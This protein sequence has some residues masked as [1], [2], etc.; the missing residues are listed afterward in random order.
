M[1]TFETLINPHRPI[2]LKVVEITGITPQMV[3]GAP[4]IEE[5]LPHFLDFLDGAV[6]VAHNALFDLGFLNYELTRLKGRR[7]GDG[8]IDTV[9]LA[10]QMAP[11]LPNY[12]LG[13]VSEALGSP[14]ASCHRALADAQGHSPRLPDS[15]R[16]PPGAGD[17]PAQPGAQRPST[18]H[19]VA[20]GTRSP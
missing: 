15:G 3:V 9:L 19:T 1:G 18:P 17:H 4:R 11:G 12:K 20:T 10:R 8:A 6:I 2:P 14:V 5:V 16:T 13:T 7:L